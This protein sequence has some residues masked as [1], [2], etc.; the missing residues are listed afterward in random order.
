MDPADFY[1]A[2]GALALGMLALLHAL[3]WRAQRKRWSMLFT[4]CMG[5][6]A[7]YYAFDP[8]LRPVGDR[9]NVVGSLLGAVLIFTLLAALVEYVG[10]P[11]RAARRLIAAAVGVGVLLLAARLAGWL[12]RVAGFAIYAAYFAL[13]AGLAAWAMRR[14][15][16]HGHGVVLASLLSYPLAVVAMSLGH[17]PP[18]LVRYVIIVPSVMLGMTVL[19]T[20]QMRERAAAQAELERRRAAEAELR[21]VNDSLEARVAERTAELRGMVAA[22]ESFNRSVSHDLRGPLGGMA[23]ALALADEALAAG[24]LD[25]VRRLLPAVKDQ[26]ESSAE[27]VH[28]L[29][30][31]AHAGQDELRR[32]HVA[33]DRLVAASLDQLRGPQAEAL[34]VT[35]GTLPAIDGDPGLLRQVFVN[36]LGNALKFSRDAVPPRVEVG[37]T[38]LQGQTVLY[39]RDNGVGFAPDAAA[40]LFE[41][42]QRL[43]GAR[44][45]G[46][47]VGLSIV[48]RIVERHGGRLWAESEP[49][50]GATFYFT[51]DGAAA[52]AT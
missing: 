32:E 10:L 18:D 6:G 29:L 50:R 24:D 52:T 33:L 3:V 41:P 45:A 15:P 51:L 27:L 42:F 23:H 40:R 19:T 22:L 2:T 11:A 16:G 47:G 21:R 25:T 35:V 28:A 34:P 48:R 43:H 17:V 39:V 4:L 49:G 8:W 9:A 20:G 31:L 30:R 1:A 12:P 14:E 7:L 46:S 26:A 5:V 13:F 37:A 38:Q 36:L 44:F